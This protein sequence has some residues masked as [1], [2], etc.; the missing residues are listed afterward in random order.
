MVL[1]AQRVPILEQLSISNAL[2][3]A[4]VPK[5]FSITVLPERSELCL[6]V[7]PKM[8]LAPRAPQV[9]TALKE[10]NILKCI[11]VL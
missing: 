5:E 7:R 6:E 9:I 4:T 8:R 1:F 3:E 2:K 10:Q 11:P